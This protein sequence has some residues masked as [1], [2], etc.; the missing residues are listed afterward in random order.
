MLYY[1]SSVAGGDDL[2][3]FT[4]TWRNMTC[5]LFTSR[6]NKSRPLYSNCFLLGYSLNAMPSWKCFLC[7]SPT[8]H[9]VCHGPVCGLDEVLIVWADWADRL[10]SNTQQHFVKIHCKDT[11]WQCDFIAIPSVDNIRWSRFSF[12]CYFC[13][14][15]GFP[16]S[17]LCR[18]IFKKVEI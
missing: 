16:T 14:Q 11:F 18:L 1:Y 7:S 13:G 9:F 2:G 5:S 10:Q 8:S 3:I 12:V 6:T 4:F 17:I 15:H